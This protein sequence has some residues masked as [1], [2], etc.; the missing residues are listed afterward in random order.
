MRK[1]QQAFWF[2]NDNRNGGDNVV[3]L[4]DDGTW[5]RTGWD[6]SEVW[7]NWEQIDIPL[8]PGTNTDSAYCKK[9][10]K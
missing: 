9:G 7:V 5:W 1:I 4:A 10:D 3:A 6:R 8:L 2:A